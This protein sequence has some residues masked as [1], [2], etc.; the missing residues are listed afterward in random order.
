MNYSTSFPRRTEVI[1]EEID[2]LRSYLS[3]LPTEWR[4]D[5][6]FV[7]YEE[8]LRALDE[9]LAV[10]QIGDLAPLL[11]K[12]PRESS[13]TPHD[14]A[15]LIALIRQMER[16]HARSSFEHARVN[17]WISYA[18]LLG[19]SATAIS[20]LASLA[21]LAIPAAA[22]TAAAAGSLVV[23]KWSERSRKEARAADHLSALR[24]EI[25]HLSAFSYA[26]HKIPE[27]FP[28]S[29]RVDTLITEYLAVKK[30]IER[31]IPPTELVED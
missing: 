26:E 9:E 10:S 7:A 16:T 20:V 29:A 28:N 21:A 6:A 11:T 31:G 18:A 5:G 22:A 12:E 1:R 3:G 2:D 23:F 15:E 24:N 30:E 8:R 27:E 13:A 4:E 25:E 14:V 19:S 17:R